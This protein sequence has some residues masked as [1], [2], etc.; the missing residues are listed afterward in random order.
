[1]GGQGRHGRRR[2]ET[3]CT[4]CE[5]V[6]GVVVHRHGPNGL[7]HKVARHALHDH[8]PICTGSGIHVQ[9]AAVM[10]GPGA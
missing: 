2:L 6:R 3:L 10:D 9:P 4:V 5:E 7:E 1:M 8:G